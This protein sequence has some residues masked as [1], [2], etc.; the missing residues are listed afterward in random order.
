MLFII[1]PLEGLGFASVY[2][3]G[4]TVMAAR[5]PAGLQGTA[6]GIFA[7]SSGLA[8]I[9]GAVAGGALA[10]AFGIP[11]LFLA[12]AGLGVVGAVIVGLALLG[13]GMGRIASPGKSA[14]AA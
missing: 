5:A 9:L 4:V 3:G 14:Q 8:A 1:E 7:A 11:G 13:P 12:M 10:A 6:Q 2:I